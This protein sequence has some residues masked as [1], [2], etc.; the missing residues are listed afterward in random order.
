MELS[1]KL[2]RIIVRPKWFNHS[3]LN[4][5]FLTCFDFSDKTVLDFGCGIGTSSIIFPKDNYIGVDCDS[6]RIKYARRLYPNNKFITMSADNIPI[7]NRSIDYIL[8]MSVLHHISNNQLRQVLNEF[9][10][11]LNNNGKIIIVE[12][13]LYQN[14][15]LCNWF[16]TH[17]DKGKYIRQ[18]SEYTRILHQADYYTHT[19]KRFH[20]LGLY[21]KIMMIASP[22]RKE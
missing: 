4:H 16:M 14:C 3:L 13:C 8:V 10:R 18:E 2:Y 17:I 19:L 21:N 7:P 6:S 9:S 5:T 20:Q 1:P 12:P 15:N 11:I 22:H